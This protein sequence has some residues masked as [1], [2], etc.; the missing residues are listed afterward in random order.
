MIS[1]TPK[2][3]DPPFEP[4]SLQSIIAQIE[5]LAR[6][7]ASAEL[8]E[9]LRRVADAA[10][11]FAA[12]GK[13]WAAG[14]AK[15]P[16]RLGG[17]DTAETA[18]KRQAV[19][20]HLLELERTQERGLYPLLWKLEDRRQEVAQYPPEVRTAWLGH[21]DGM[22]SGIREPLD[23]IRATRIALQQAECTGIGQ[24]AADN[25]AIDQ[26]AMIGY[27]KIADEVFHT[28]CAIR[29][30]IVG[31]ERFYIIEIP[32]TD[33]GV[34]HRNEEDRVH[35]VMEDLAPEYVGRVAF[36][37]VPRRGAA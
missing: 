34:S 31:G 10:R 28:E 9:E 21:L 37:Y 4:Q 26:R 17:E 33:A 13:H 2:I 5:D 3:D 16:N 12:D 7:E 22:I 25:S 27:K 20:S 32:V 35:S 14:I 19:V 24:E 6:R 36:H 15:W 18:I 1:A 11:R 29:T 23:I 30:E 8:L